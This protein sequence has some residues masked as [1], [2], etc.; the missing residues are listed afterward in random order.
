M[1]GGSFSQCGF[2]LCAVHT[3]LKHSTSLKDGG[4]PV[5]NMWLSSQSR[6]HVSQEFAAASRTEGGQ[7]FIM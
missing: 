7:F 6:A 4:R 1:E 2:C 3:R 5:L